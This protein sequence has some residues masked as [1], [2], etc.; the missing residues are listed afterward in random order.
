M[1]HGTNDSGSDYWFMALGWHGQLI[2]KGKALCDAIIDDIAHNG[3]DY[4]TQAY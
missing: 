4:I 2:K 1:R 3:S